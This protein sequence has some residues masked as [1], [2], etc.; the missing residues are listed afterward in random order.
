VVT[1]DN[2]LKI[3]YI[4]SSHYFILMLIFIIYGVV[5]LLITPAPNYGSYKLILFSL[6][7]FTFVLII[8]LIIQNIRFFINCSIL[9]FS[10]FMCVIILRFGTN[11]LI[12]SNITERF[13]TDLANSISIGRYFGL[14]SI[15]YFLSILSAKN[16]LYKILM[17][18][19]FTCSVLLIIS[20]GSKGPLFSVIVCFSSFY[21][22][23]I[24]KLLP[25]I[26]VVGVLFLFID[27]IDLISKIKTSDFLINRF[28]ENVGSYT[29]RE[30][31]MKKTL[32]EYNNSHIL[33]RLFGAGV[34]SAGFL[35]NLKDVADYPHNIVIEILYEFGI[36]GV[37]LLTIIFYKGISRAVKSK[38]SSHLS[39]FMYFWMS[40]VFLFMNSFVSGDFTNNVFVF[41]FLYFLYYSSGYAKKQNMKL[42]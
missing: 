2:S 12:I 41:G 17:F 15:F 5:S 37:I 3:K 27:D 10:I 33:T 31:I 13:Q 32:I 24:R 19:F 36:I 16:N 21:L 39:Y 29:P 7:F 40:F 23:N 4:I 30:E 9:V 26:I 18:A 38:M 35:L 6:Q 14:A 11:I 25:L 8:P 22:A 34:G 1:N 42:L 20:T 28:I